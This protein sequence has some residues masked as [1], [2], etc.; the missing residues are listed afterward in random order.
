MQ[1][2]IQHLVEKTK[3]QVFIQPYILVKNIINN[4]KIIDYFS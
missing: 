3:I 2:D 1:F 4:I